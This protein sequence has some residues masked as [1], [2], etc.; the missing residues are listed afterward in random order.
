MG[1]ERRKDPADRRGASG[2]RLRKGEQQPGEIYDR[3]HC[4][5]RSGEIGAAALALLGGLPLE[6]PP[7]RDPHPPEREHD[8]GNARPRL[9]REKERPRENARQ[10]AAETVQRGAFE[11]H[12]PPVA[13]EDAKAVPEHRQ[14]ENE[15]RAERGQARHGV[16]KEKPC[17]ERREKADRQ[18]RAPEGIEKPPALDGRERFSP[19][20]E[21]R[22]ILH[23]PAHPAVR[24]GKIAHRTG[25]EAVGQLHVAHIP[26]AEKR[27]LERVVAQYAP[28]GNAFPQ[29]R[30]ICPHMDEPLPREAAALEGVH[31]HLPGVRAVGIAAGRGG[32]E[33]R[34]VVPIRALERHGDA[35]MQ[36]AVAA[37]N[38]SAFGIDRRAVERVER[39]ADELSGA[40][41]LETRVGVERE[42][43]A[44]GAQ[45]LRVSGADAKSR[46]LPGEQTAKLQQ[47]AALSLPGS[48]FS[49]VPAVEPVAGEKI[50]APAAARVERVG[51]RG[52]MIE[53]GAVGVRE[54]FAA[55]RKIAQK[56]E[57]KVFPAAAGGSAKFLKPPERAVCGLLPRE[58]YRQHADRL[59]LGRDAVFQREARQ[60]ARRHGAEQ[61]AVQKSLHDFRDRQQRQHSREDAFCPQRARRRNRKREKNVCENVRRAAS[62]GHARAEGIFIEPV[63][64]MTPPDAL[65]ALGQ[66]QRLLR[67]ARLAFIFPPRKRF[68]ARAVVP[69]AALVHALVHPRR[70]APED[71]LHGVGLFQHR[72]QIERG[73]V[74]Q[75][76]KIYGGRR[77]GGCL[78]PVEL[79]EPDEDRRA[80]RRAK[81]GQLAP[82][83]RRF[84]L[85]AFQKYG[86]PFLVHAPAA[87]GEQHPAERGDERPLARGAKPP[88][89]MER[90]ERGGSLPLAQPEIV[91]Q[92][93]RAAVGCRRIQPPALFAQSAQ[94]V[95][96]LILRHGARH[97][98]R[99]GHRARRALGIMRQLFKRY[100]DRFHSFRLQSMTFT[101]HFSPMSGTICKKGAAG[102]PAAPEPVGFLFY[103]TSRA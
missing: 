23:V 5:E 78:A 57:E 48:K 60:M 2:E 49:A 85:K 72:V 71:V 51:L 7:V 90:G 83:E 17:A 34:E 6:Q 40:L 11:A 9:R 27:P 84:P 67:D 53:Q 3:P 70:V 50:K 41:R 65:G 32:K 95:P 36:H 89:G 44:R 1:D 69:A 96:D 39:C 86:D 87:G 13:K 100:H 54:R 12:L 74:P 97:H 19:P 18:Q 62:P 79:R 64:D 35:R 102:D 75:R 68:D 58:Q 15:Q 77:A 33:A 8:R 80:Q 22:Q 88:G 61:R 52:G 103:S 20:E 28:F 94:R 92:P 81:K 73:D 30:E 16:R 66:A 24:A 38:D 45:L 31:I 93:A 55:L 82:G 29:T 63:A 99:H 91:K 25:G 98:A 76:C 4:G 59:S 46:V 42:D 26:A 37:K 14:E 43:I 47:R 21:P 10:L 56:T 101:E